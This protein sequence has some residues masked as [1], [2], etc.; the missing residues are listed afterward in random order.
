MPCPAGKIFFSSRGY[1]A[2]YYCVMYLFLE[3]CQLVCKGID[4]ASLEIEVKDIL[5]KHKKK[6]LTKK[7]NELNSLHRK[8]KRTRQTQGYMK[9]NSS[10]KIIKFQTFKLEIKREV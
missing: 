3:L 2:E 4:D 7:N 10:G 6:E 9:I 1:F 5:A 8:K